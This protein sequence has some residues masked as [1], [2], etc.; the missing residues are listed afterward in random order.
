MT[1]RTGGGSGVRRDVLFGSSLFDSDREG[2]N[3][4]KLF[5]K[6]N[7]ESAVTPHILGRLPAELILSDPPAADH[8]ARGRAKINRSRAIHTKVI[9]Q[10]FG[11]HARD[12]GESRTIS[13]LE[14]GRYRLR[15]GTE[16]AKSNLEID[17]LTARY[18]ER[19]SNQL[20][21]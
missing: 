11:L 12:K 18:N 14:F 2:T 16:I 19:K 6:L 7:D 21:L 20:S 13:N 1:A 3:C 10:L 4:R 9:G 17:V 5:L 15:N 8:L